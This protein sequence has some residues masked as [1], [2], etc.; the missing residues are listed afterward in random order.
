MQGA[1]VIYGRD[2]GIHV[3]GHG[4]QEDQ[5]LM[6]SLTRPKYFIPVHGEHRM[7]IKH[8]QT[9]QSTGIPAENMVII[10]NGD[11]VELTENSICKAGKVPSGIQLVD[12][13]GIVH[14][15][16]QVMEERKQLAG[17]GVVTVALAIGLDGKMMVKPQVNLR[18]VVT[19]VEQS[20]ISALIQKTIEN[21]LI[22]RWD[23]F[24]RTFESGQR[25]IDWAG[26]Q[27]ELESAL[28][29]L[30]RREL[31]SKP[32]LV[33]MMQT[34]EDDATPRKASVAT[35]VAA[36]ELVGAGVGATPAPI[37]RRKQRSTAK[38]E[39]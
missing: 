1:N 30:V 3:S 28:Q 36:K 33:L 27:I 6:L 12:N 13:A 26:L 29:R 37:G 9:A 19:A 16:A 10:D 18:G 8:S 32:L 11:I 24:A 17:D 22:D 5:K 34:P 38:V 23:R 7:L 31:Q 15:Q 35:S 39:A 20:L 21:C 14:D 2:K 25:E 4:C